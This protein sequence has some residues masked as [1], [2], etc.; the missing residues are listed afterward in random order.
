MT[1]N[2][3]LKNS[4]KVHPEA[5]N[6]A[7]SGPGMQILGF[8]VSNF[9]GTKTKKI[10]TV[11]KSQENPVAYTS[12]LEFS[13]MTNPT[14]EIVDLDKH[15]FRCRCS[16]FTGDTLVMLANGTSVPIKDLVGREEFFTFSYDLENKKPVIGRGHSAHL[17]RENAPIYKVTLDNGSVVKCTGDHK[18]L[19]NSGVYKE[20]KDLLEGDSLRAIYRKRYK[21]SFLCQGYRMLASKGFPYRMEHYLSDEYNLDSDIYNFSKGEI[22]HH[23]DFN[24]DNNDPTNILR[25]TK[26]EHNKIHK[27]DTSAR[28]KDKNPMFYPEVVSK[29]VKTRKEKGLNTGKY[30]FKE[31]IHIAQVQV[32]DGTHHWLLEKHSEKM[33]AIAHERSCK[34]LLPTQVSSR[35]KSHHWMSNRTER[36]LEASIKNASN[37]CKNLSKDQLKNRA[38]KSNH[39][40]YHKSTPFDLCD[41]CNKMNH[42]VV[43]VEFCGYEDVYDLTVD[44]YHNFTIDVDGGKDCSSGVIV[45][46]CPNFYF[47]FGYWDKKNEVLS[48]PSQKKYVRKTKTRPEVNPQHLPGMCKHILRVIIALKHNKLAKGG[49]I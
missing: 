9:R 8:K 24:P 5:I 1:F 34:G 46:N 15:K 38:R 16:C 7:R 44:K 27:V 30:F 6:K 21:G 20:A 23:R 39:S 22:R 19:L 41:I 26:E 17:T 12:I 42:K 35:N 3:L 33:A 32:K 13:G 29:V 28:M 18:W 25:V 10:F 43:S 4:F 2:D 37:I 31:G 36:Q 45:H 47:M 49:N 14:D 11:V 40:R 48:G